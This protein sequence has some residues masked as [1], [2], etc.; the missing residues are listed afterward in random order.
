MNKSHVSNHKNLFFII[1]IITILDSR[2]DHFLLR[3]PLK[4]NYESKIDGFQS[5]KRDDLTTITFNGLTYSV[6]IVR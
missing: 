4:K 6:Q 5:Q 2:S 1:P 3:K